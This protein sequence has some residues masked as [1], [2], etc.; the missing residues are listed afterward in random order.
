MNNSH[1]LKIDTNVFHTIPHFTPGISILK[2]HNENNYKKW[3][4]SYCYSMYLHTESLLKSIIHLTIHPTTTHDFCEMLDTY[5][6]PYEIIN[7]QTVIELLNNGYYIWTLYNTFHVSK[8]IYAYNRY[9]YPHWVLVHGYSKDESELNVF[10]ADFIFNNSR[11]YS[12]EMFPLS[13]FLK[14]LKNIHFEELNKGYSYGVSA[15][16]YKEM[17]YDVDKPLLIK[18]I[19]NHLNSSEPSYY[20]NWRPFKEHDGKINGL[21]A[22][23]AVIDAISS[24]GEIDFHARRSLYIL[25]IHT[26]IVNQIVNYFYCDLIDLSVKFVDLAKKLAQYSLKLNIQNTFSLND[27]HK[28]ETMITDLELLDEEISS[29]LYKY[30]VSHV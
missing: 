6:I 13:E 21:K 30:L 23:R 14:S 26:Q 19:I 2:A 1:I 11:K 25:S 4:M 18:C 22:Y 28:I 9:H 7:K 10:G 12:S 16:K 5:V 24:L 17:E 29:K 27:Y 15:I 20:Y 8:C 3:I